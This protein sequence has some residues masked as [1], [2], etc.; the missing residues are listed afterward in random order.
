VFVYAK[1]LLAVT[2]EQKNPLLSTAAA[3]LVALTGSAAAPD[4]NCY[5]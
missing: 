2:P 4:G 1:G 5:G 3:T